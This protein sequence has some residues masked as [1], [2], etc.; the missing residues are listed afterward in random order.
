MK[1][2]LIIPLCLFC[3]YTHAQK[4]QTFDIA[5]FTVPGGWQK[6]SGTN[7]VTGY[8][9]T[10][11]K[12][13]TYAQIAVYASTAT[14]GN[15]QAD[16]ESEWQELIVKTYKPKT[17]PQLS[18][19]ETIDGWGAQ[20]GAA[21]FEFNGAPSAALLVTASGPTRCISIV[22]LTNT[23]EYQPQIQAFLESVDLANSDDVV[24][25]NGNN[26]QTIKT[27]PAPAASGSFRF[28]T[29][30]FDDGWTSTVQEDWVHVAKGNI[31]V[32]LHFNSHLVDLSSANH[33][34]ISN[35]AWNTLV[36]PRYTSLSNYHVLGVTLNYDRPY[37]ISG[38][39]TDNKTGK[40]VFVSLFRKTNTDWVEIICPDRQTFIKAFGVD[41]PKVS[42]DVDDNIW[43]ALSKLRGYNK[44]AVDASDLKGTWTNDYSASTQYVNAYSGMTV[45]M[46]TYSSYE[47]FVFNTD[48][49]YK[50]N[51]GSVSGFVGTLKAQSA[52]SSGKFTVPNNWQVS[53][54]DIEGKPKTYDAS[55]SCTRGGR[56][57]WFGNTGFVRAD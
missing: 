33:V 39:V 26:Q 6:L 4:R 10:D 17:A 19:E 49:T 8:A 31:V 35:N 38:E 5:T 32:L 51:I 20:A 24:S 29:T 25:S 47:T 36:A 28:T 14:R 27:N 45:G 15:L 56:I 23:D 9:I 44:F 55:F 41:A 3:M 40:R 2:L 30:N 21:E 50:W 1:N 11:A 57:L 53:F 22:V 43:S 48:K 42:Y 52:K 46:D 34:T 12:K 37:L 54:S 18:P 13:G 7:N 16:F